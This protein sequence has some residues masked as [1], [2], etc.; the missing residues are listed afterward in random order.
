MLIRETV[1]QLLAS[2]HFGERWARYWM[3]LAR[4]ADTKGYV[5]QESREYPEAFRYRDWLITA[6][7]EDLP[8]TAFIQKQLAADLV[9]KAAPADL[10]ALGFLT[11]GRRFLNN[12]NDIIDDRLDVVSRGLMGMTLAC[13]R[14]H[15]HKYD[16]VT[17]ADYYALY[18]VFLNTEEPGGEP[19][20]HRMVDTKEDR[21]SFILVR[22]SPGNRGVASRTTICKLHVSRLGR[23]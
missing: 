2:P 5:F 7:N 22:G 6:F 15:D 3:D 19:F 17:Q 1:D 13:A 9:P 12:K 14:C 21:K 8:Y 23:I 18:G 4:Y 11:L 10:P 16:P 20:A